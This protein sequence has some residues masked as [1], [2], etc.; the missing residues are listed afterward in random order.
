MTD[1]RRR[2]GELGAEFA[3]YAIAFLILGG[4]FFA[5]AVYLRTAGT[6]RANSSMAV[7][8]SIVPCGGGAL[9]NDQCL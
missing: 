8:S 6:T 9:T 4:A 7:S 2:R 3:E 5:A 1:A